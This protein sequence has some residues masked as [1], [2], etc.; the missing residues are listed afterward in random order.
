[1]DNAFRLSDDIM[2]KHVASGIL[3]LIDRLQQPGTGCAM[4]TSTLK[5]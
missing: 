5:T 2:P 1:M 4:A 3:A